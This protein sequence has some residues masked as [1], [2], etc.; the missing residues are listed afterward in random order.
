M[1]EIDRIVL[2]AYALPA[3]L[4]NDL[5]AYMALGPRPGPVPMRITDVRNRLGWLVDKKHGDEITP[6]EAG[7][8]RR[9]ESILDDEEEAFYRPFTEKLSAIHARLAQTHKGGE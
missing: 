7:E 8:I 5:E 6:D 4:R 2:E 1:A 3:E 9:L